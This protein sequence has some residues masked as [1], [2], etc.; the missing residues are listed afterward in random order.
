MYIFLFLRGGLSGTSSDWKMS[1][2]TT[3]VS[4]GQSG[5]SVW[6]HSM[7]MTRLC[8][9]RWWI[10]RMESGTARARKAGREPTAWASVGHGSPLSEFT[11]HKSVGLPRQFSS[12]LGCTF[13]A[14]KFSQFH[15]ITGIL[16]STYFGCF[17]FCM[18]SKL[19]LKICMLEIK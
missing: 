11:I 6:L 12:Y 8:W 9:S 5:T 4:S 18:L 13:T 15:L 1:T 2:W 10:K 3:V 7:L 16:A 17:T 14:N 19:S